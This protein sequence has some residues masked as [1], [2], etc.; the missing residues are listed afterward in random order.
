MD[1]HSR[2]SESSPSSAAFQ[3][4]SQQSGGKGGNA[5]KTCM[6]EAGGREVG[7]G[8]EGRRGNRVETCRE[9]AQE[10]RGKGGREGGEGGEGGREGGRR[11]R[12]EGGEGGGR[13]GG[14]GGERE[15]GGREGGRI[16][17]LPCRHLEK[18][19]RP[20]HQLTVWSSCQ[21]PGG[22]RQESKVSSGTLGRAI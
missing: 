11:G 8:G 5:V 9:E 19:K 1:T 18:Q 6:E 2:A 21:L 13:E 17:R 4:A 14:E 3:S 15:E 16:G 12:R 10:G 7:K 20:P 22:Q